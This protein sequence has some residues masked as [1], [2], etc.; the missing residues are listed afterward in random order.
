MSSEIY[1]LLCQDSLCKRHTRNT[2][3]KDHRDWHSYVVCASSAHVYS[4]LVLYCDTYMWTVSVLQCLHDHSHDWTLTLWMTVNGLGYL[5]SCWHIPEWLPLM[6]YSHIW[7]DLI[8]WSI[9]FILPAF[10]C[11][12]ECIMSSWYLRS[13][14]SLDLLWCMC[15]TFLCL[16]PCTVQYF[17]MLDLLWLAEIDSLNF[18][19]ICVLPKS[20]IYETCTTLSVSSISCVYLTAFLSPDCLIIVRTCTILE[21]H[22]SFTLKQSPYGCVNE[23]AVSYAYN[24]V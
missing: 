4:V 11:M 18:S 16:N 9:A 5:Q 1:F 14:D 17:G 7:C 21:K 13:D 22:D 2:L 15:T 3:N 23:Y 12:C 6:L 24:S 10:L 19:T 20:S 8:G